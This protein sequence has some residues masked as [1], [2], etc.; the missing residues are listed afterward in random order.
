MIGIEKVESRRFTGIR[1]IEIRRGPHND[2]TTKVREIVDGAAKEC[3][4][5]GVV[6]LRRGAVDAGAVGE[7]S[8]GVFEGLGEEGAG[9]IGVGRGDVAFDDGWGIG[10]GGECGRGGVVGAIGNGGAGV[11]QGG[12]LSEGDGGLFECVIELEDLGAV[13]TLRVLRW[14]GR[15]LR[16]VAGREVAG[17]LSSIK[18]ILK[19]YLHGVTG[20]GDG[21]E[22]RYFRVD[23]SYTGDEKVGCSEVEEGREDE[24]SHGGR[25]IYLCPSSASIF[26][27]P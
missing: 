19:C 4:E 21:A 13:D 17:D 15:A 12:G 18:L 7:K 11:V 6:F 20:E 26:G 22:S 27:T 5:R 8:G 24:G 14:R 10:A 23:A 3:F 16:D 25:G 2:N 1:A 9:E